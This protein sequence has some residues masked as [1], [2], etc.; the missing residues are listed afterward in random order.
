[1]GEQE[2][3]DQFD[4][5][6]PWDAPENQ[7]VAQEMPAVFAGTSSLDG[8]DGAKGTT[9]NLR[10]IG[11][12]LGVYKSDDPPVLEN[13]STKAISSSVVIEGAGVD[14]VQ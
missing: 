2:L 1:M 10:V 3:Y 5:S 4:F 14:A 7:K 12:K 11:G 6:L 13:V 8:D 9:T